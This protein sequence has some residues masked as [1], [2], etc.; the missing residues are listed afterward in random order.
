MLHRYPTLFIAVDEGSKLIETKLGLAFWPE[1]EGVYVIGVGHLDLC[2][3]QAVEYE[4]NAE[5]LAK[6]FDIFDCGKYKHVYGVKLG[7]W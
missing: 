4:D 2:V 1:Q 3:I 6:P 5:N 7:E